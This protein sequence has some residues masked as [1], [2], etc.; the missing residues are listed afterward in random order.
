MN[1]IIAEITLFVLVALSIGLARDFFKQFN[2]QDSNETGQDYQIFATAFRY[3]TIGFVL[4]LA[5]TILIGVS[6]GLAFML[7]LVFTFYVVSHSTKLV[8]NIVEACASK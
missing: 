7:P 3:M 4:Y 5:K 6:T 8:D 1:I 2:R